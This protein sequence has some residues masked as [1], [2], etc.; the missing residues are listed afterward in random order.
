MTDINLAGGAYVWESLPDSYKSI[1][2]EVTEKYFPELRAGLREDEEK[3][4]MALI[5]KGMKIMEQSPEFIAEVKGRIN[6]L[7]QKMVGKYYP[8][9]LLKGVLDIRNQCRASLQK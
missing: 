3:A 6:E 1:V 5:E 9:W 8:D 4:K 7:Y 2:K